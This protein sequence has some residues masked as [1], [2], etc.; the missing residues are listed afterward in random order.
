V[1]QTVQLDA[2]SDILLRGA[3]PEVPVDGGEAVKDMVI[4]QAI[5]AAAKTGQKVMLKG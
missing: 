5:Y 3:K 2:M 4:V 1:H